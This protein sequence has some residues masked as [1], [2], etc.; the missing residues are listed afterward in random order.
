MQDKELLLALLDSESEDDVIAN[1][2][3][4]DLFDE[5]NAKRWVALGKMPNNQSVVQNQQST[6]AA[7]LVEKFTNALDAACGGCPR[8]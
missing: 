3:K 5:K 6:P 8:I 4:L 1:L 7:A 2:S